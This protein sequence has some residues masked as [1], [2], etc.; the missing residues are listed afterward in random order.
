MGVFDI[1]CRALD[2]VNEEPVARFAALFFSYTSLSSNTRHPIHQK[3]LDFGLEHTLA[4]VQASEC[5]YAV[6]H[7]SLA[8]AVLQTN[9]EIKPHITFQNPLADQFI[10]QGHAFDKCEKFRQENNRRTAFG[11]APPILDR[12]NPLLYSD[13]GTVQV[14][15]LSIFCIQ[16]HKCYL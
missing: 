5:D 11:T 8:L 13:N 1:V 2:R 3:M 10:S 12:I 7:A 14:N 6:F 9:K 16:L 15:T 4:I